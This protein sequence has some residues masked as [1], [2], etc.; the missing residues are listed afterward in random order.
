LADRLTVKAKC[1]G[2]TRRG[3]ENGHGEAPGG[4]TRLP[5]PT[6]PPGTPSFPLTVIPCGKSERAGENPRCV[7]SFRGPTARAFR[8][9]PTRVR[10]LFSAMLLSPRRSGA[11]AHPQSWLQHLKA[12]LKLLDNNPT[13]TTSQG[14]SYYEITSVSWNLSQSSCFQACQRGGWGCGVY[15]VC[16]PTLRSLHGD[17]HIEKASPAAR[18]PW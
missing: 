6:H 10:R 4:E 3:G 2:S 7:S 13:T 18:P 5:S 1:W 8:Q 11:C 9:L 16:G 12:A 17:L 14:S 15:G